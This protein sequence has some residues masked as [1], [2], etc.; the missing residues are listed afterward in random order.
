MSVRILGPFELELQGLS[1]SASRAVNALRDSSLVWRLATSAPDRAGLYWIRGDAGLLGAWITL[2]A[3]WLTDGALADDVPPIAGPVLEALVE[4]AWWRGLGLPERQ[5]RPL[6]VLEWLGPLAERC[7]TPPPGVLR[8]SAEIVSALAQERL[9]TLNDDTEEWEGTNPDITDSRPYP[10]VPRARPESHDVPVTPAPTRPQTLWDD[11]E[12]WEGTN[13]D[14]TDSRPIPPRTLADPDAPAL[15]PESP[16]VPEDGPSV[17]SVLEGWLRLSNGV[18]RGSYR[19]LRASRLRELEGD[20]PCA[21]LE[22]A[23]ADESSSADGDDEPLALRGLG[24]RRC[25]ALDGW[26]SRDLELQ[27]SAAEVHLPERSVRHPWVGLAANAMLTT[28]SVFLVAW[29]LGA[30]AIRVADPAPSKTPPA[31][32]VEPGPAISPCSADHTPFVEEFRCQIDRLSRPDWRADGAPG[33]GDPDAES[34]PAT[35]AVELQ[36]AYCGLH[37]R[38]LDGWVGNFWSADSSGNTPKAFDFAE[39]AAAQACYNTLRHPEAYRQTGAPRWADPD[40]FLRDDT[41][42]VEQLLGVMKDLDLSCEQTRARMEARLTGAIV[43][44]HIGAIEP[45]AEVH[46]VEAWYAENGA[47]RDGVREIVRDFT[48]NLVTC[49]DAG[50]TEGSGVTLLDKLCG[51]PTSDAKTSIWSQLGIGSSSGSAVERYALARFGREAAT[52]T[53]ELL[54]QCHLQL[55]RDDRA[56]PKARVPVNWGLMLPVPHA[57]GESGT[58]VQSQLTLDA[59]LRSFE[60]AGTNA[61]ACW[62]FVQERLARYTPVHPLLT[63]LREDGTVQ[64]EQ[65]LCAQVCATKFG[66]VRSQ[67]ATHWWTREADLSACVSTE[68]PQEVDAPLPA[69]VACGDSGV[70][71]GMHVCYPGRIPWNKSWYHWEDP[72]HRGRRIGSPQR[73]DNAPESRAP[74]VAQVCA[75]QLIAQDMLDVGKNPLLGEDMNGIAWAGTHPT[76]A[77][78]AGGQSG[79]ALHSLLKM[80]VEM[81]PQSPQPMGEYGERPCADVA[82]QCFVSLMLDVMAKNENQPYTWVGSWNQQISALQVRDGKETWMENPWCAPIAPYLDQTELQGAP[83]DAACRLGILEARKNVGSALEASARGQLSEGAP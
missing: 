29:G 66:V 10:P 9:P 80:H 18:H 4:T 83:G 28:S 13:P 19:L 48:V 41:Y 1:S 3:R 15:P 17:I 33:C 60:E 24:G 42:R 69:D 57:Y 27:S 39:L 77:G 55:T 65:Q 59:A 67:A 46:D 53:R 5:W 82:T 14:I 25:F 32:T 31:P 75:F 56:F 22:R 71:D 34:E 8:E 7:H 11:L 2:D 37:D 38:E 58:G 47:F 79:A 20:A 74:T 49:F 73:Y 70:G 21:W 12:D 62:R 78:V 44:T 68:A 23:A 6:L 52:G 61:G 30:V 76:T 26:L 81:G 35:V 54:W 64:P 16:R 40:R 45:G 50:W 43:A 51:A 72:T 36:T 63:E